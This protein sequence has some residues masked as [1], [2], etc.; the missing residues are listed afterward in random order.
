MDWSSHDWLLVTTPPKP[1]GQHIPGWVGMP[2]ELLEWFSSDLAAAVTEHGV[3]VVVDQ[4]G[5]AREFLLDEDGYVHI[6][7]VSEEA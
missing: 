3:V 5:C 2:L 7:R 4:E 6:T 1:R